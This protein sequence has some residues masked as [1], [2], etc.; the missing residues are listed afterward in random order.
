[1]ALRPYRPDP[2]GFSELGSAASRSRP[3]D[4]ATAT[5][6]EI[7]AALGLTMPEEL[8]DEP[9]VPRSRWGNVLQS[10]AGIEGSDA[11]YQGPLASLFSGAVS[12]IGAA[13]TRAQKTQ[14][15]L[16]EAAQERRVKR[17]QENLEATRKYRESL[18]R[19]RG[20]L[21]KEGREETRAITRETRAEERA[22]PGQI[23]AEAAAKRQEEAGVRAE[24]AG[25]RA[26]QAAVRAAN[27]TE[28]QIKVQ[29]AQTLNQLADDYNKDPDV[30]TYRTASQNLAT[31]EKAA[32]LKSGPGDLAMVVS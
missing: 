16:E 9:A 29:T 11:P 26:E 13:G 3:F 27:A 15:R 12:G 6:E 18:T 10:M 2:A 21:L 14:L 20:E 32:K 31:I 17:D 23:R 1:M 24:A 4:P 19:G 25:V 28:R 8:P 7:A 22:K 30:V 5:D